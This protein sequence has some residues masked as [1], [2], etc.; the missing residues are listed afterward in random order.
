MATG[1]ER[2]HFMEG[3]WDVKAFIT[4]D[5]GEWVSSP[6]PKET[7][8]DKLLGGAFIKED[9][10]IISDGEENTSYF[11]IWSYDQ[12]RKIYQML[13]GN[14]SDGSVEILE[15]NFVGDTIIVDNLRTGV[16]MPDADGQETYMQLSSVQTADSFEDTVSISV[17]KKVWTPVYRAMHTRRA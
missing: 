6:F 11:V 3:E 15:G 5:T 13:V 12:Y 16:A 10:V 7:K 9:E 4:N 1:I 14:K 8:V 17:D 2:L